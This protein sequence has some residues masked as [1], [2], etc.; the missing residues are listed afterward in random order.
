MVVQQG[1]L[2]SVDTTKNMENF[3]N[4]SV[5][6]STASVDRIIHNGTQFVRLVLRR[7]QPETA[8]RGNTSG[9]LRTSTPGYIDS[10]FVANTSSDINLITIGFG[11]LITT[12]TIKLFSTS[13]ISATVGNWSVKT[14]LND[15]E[16][17]YAN[18]AFNAAISTVVQA[19][20]PT[21]DGGNQF[22]Y[23]ITVSSPAIDTTGV[24]LPFWRITHVT[25]GAFNNVSEVQILQPLTPTISYFDTDGSFASSFTFQEANILDAAYDTINDVFYTIRFNTDNVGTSTVGVDDTFSE[26]DAGTASGT[27]NFNPAR[28]NESNVNTQFLRVSDKLSYNAATGK[29]QIETNYTLTGDFSVKL[30]VTPTTITTKPMWFTMRALDDNNNTIMSEGI[31][32]ETSPTTTGVWFVNRIA[33]L[34][35]ATASCD[36]REVRPLWHSSVS[37]TDSFNMTFNGST[38]AVSGT[39][40]G[41][42]SNATTGV[43]Y[44]T[45]TDANTP[46]EFLISSTSSP[47]LG[48]QFTFDLITDYVTK[49]PTATG[50]LKMTRAS[51]DFTTNNVLLSP[52]TVPIDP[53]TIELFGNTN[54]SI[55]VSADNYDVLSG[56]AQFPSI[57]VFTVEKTDNEGDV[58][59]PPLIESFDVIGDPSL[60][61][62]DFLEGRVQIAATSSG[63]G[64]GF[65]YI[66]INNILYKYPNNVALGT[67]TGGSATITTTAQIPKDG[68]NSFAWTH[69]SG[70]G[71][72]P[73]LTYIEHDSTL[74]ITH[75]KTINHVTLQD[76]TDSK[77]VLLDISSS[78]TSQPLKVFYDQN[79]FDT[80]YFVDASTNLKSFNI[81]DRISAFMAVNAEDVT[82]PA[83]TSQQTF[84]NADVINAWG[85]SLD[86]KTVTFSVTAGDGAVTPST[87]VTSGGGRATTQFTVGSTVGVSTVTATVTET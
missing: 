9:T 38:W 19:I 14:S 67:E 33:N 6:T 83:G 46:L 5:V 66:K 4:D 42:R 56:S 81:D 17:E 39:L 18:S 54:G 3:Y 60:T 16:S 65:V 21:A 8:T 70:V 63:T 78:Y 84:V 87:D 37:G 11:K 77:Q 36:L 45:T 12:T 68:T 43:I 41:A 71:G 80:L 75:L 57:A 1:R 27:N 72:L 61:Y 13:S 31:G 64:G 25:P 58:I 32:L 2:T 48:E 85:E 82:L 49:F 44:D 73:F 20:V 55:N 10:S 76:T 15:L 51:A 52:V 59:N 23:T 28:W 47:T 34:I 7:P 24:G 35:N 62:N 86:G 74:N 30:D 29:G 26:A 22:Q 69:E 40:T 53:V 79:D 50:V